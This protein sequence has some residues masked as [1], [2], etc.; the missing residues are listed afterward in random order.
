[1]SIPKE[2]DNSKDY[3]YSDDDLVKMYF[4][5]FKIQKNLTKEEENEIFALLNSYPKDSKEYEEVRNEIA[6]INI[7]L[8]P[9]Y[10]KY[11]KG[12][13]LSYID[14]IGEGNIGLI[15]AIEKFDLEK[16][17]KFNTFAKWWIRQAI[18]RA[19]ADTARTIRLPVHI[20]EKI[21]KYIQENDKL[22][23]TLGRE[24]S[25]SELAEAMEEPEEK[26]RLYKYLCK[27]K[28]SLD[29]PIGE[30]KEH[31]L[32]TLIKDETA[33]NPVEIVEGIIT[34]E[35]ID[36]LLDTTLSDR[37]NNIIR[38]KYGLTED[39]KEY[40]LEELGKEENVSKQRVEQ[41]EKRALHKLDNNIKTKRLFKD[42][43]NNKNN[44]FSKK[45]RR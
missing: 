28:A 10:A 16:N 8:V 35:N 27:E 29:A 7:R 4:A 1:M 24:P 39:N 40:T 11:Y 3:D 44:N 9:Y 33:D 22:F 6:E 30:D 20:G 14:L 25:I 38:K 43:I 21:Y 17:V 2:K 45:H 31:T 42:D 19:I 5:E 32:I 37:E 15:Q 18:T 26:I 41:I 12:R 34:R 36:Y 13:G 23:Q